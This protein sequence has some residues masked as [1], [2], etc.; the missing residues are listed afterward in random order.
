MIIIT[1]TTVKITNVHAHKELRCMRGRLLLPLL[2]LLLWLSPIVDII[3]IVVAVAV[4]A[5]TAYIVKLNHKGH[6]WMWPGQG[7]DNF[8]APTADLQ[9]VC[10]SAFRQYH[11]YQTPRER[12][13]FD[14]RSFSYAGP[15]VWNS[16]PHHVQE[17]TNT[18]VFKNNLNP[19]YF[20][21]RSSTRCRFTV[22]FRF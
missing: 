10:L 5:E 20:E 17:I 22:T 3:V 21:Q 9:S 14:K 8:H 19:F 2:L 16:F 12:A 18:T 4:V 1:I 13:K 11:H 6:G 15:S 7:W